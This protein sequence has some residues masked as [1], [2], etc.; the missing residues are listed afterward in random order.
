MAKIYFGHPINTYD[1]DLEK[2]LLAK[3]QKTFPGWWIINP[4]QEHHQKAYQEW[5]DKYGSG[6]NY[7]YEEVLPWCNSGIFLPFRDGKWGAGVFGEAQFLDQKNKP[8]YQ[9]THDMIILR[10]GNL[11]RIPAL[12]V[13]ETRIRI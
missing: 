13:E 6:M 7:Y 1:S 12:S 4:N 5:K 3:I 8:I 9:I 11:S 2:D 10:I